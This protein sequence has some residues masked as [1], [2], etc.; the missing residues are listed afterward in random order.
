MEKAFVFYV[1]LFNTLKKQLEDH[2]LFY[3]RVSLI[4]DICFSFRKYLSPKL[5]DHFFTTYIYNS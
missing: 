1:F 5:N 4:S 2:T 3:K